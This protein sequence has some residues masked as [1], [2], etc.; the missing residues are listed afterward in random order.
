VKGK[1]PV[2]EGESSPDPVFVTLLF[3][4]CNMHVM[5]Q[6]EWR[7]RRLVL[8]TYA[9]TSKGICNKMHTKKNFFTNGIPSRRK[10]SSGEDDKSVPKPD[11]QRS[12]AGG[13]EDIHMGGCEAIRGVIASIG[14]GAAGSCASLLRVHAIKWVLSREIIESYYPLWRLSSLSPTRS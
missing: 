10:H 5:F 1:Y 8:T 9:H 3:L 7:F 12:A 14:V 11:D 4:F 6:S 13:D 2:K